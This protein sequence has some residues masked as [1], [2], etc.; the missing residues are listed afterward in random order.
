MFDHIH[1]IQQ[2][3]SCVGDKSCGVY[4][5]TAPSD[6]AGLWFGATHLQA[7]S[8]NITNRVETGKVWLNDSNSTTWMGTDEMRMIGSDQGMFT[9]GSGINAF[10]A[11][12]TN[13]DNLRGADIT[14]SSVAGSTETIFSN[15][16]TNNVRGGHAVHYKSDE[17]YYTS[18]AQATL[19]NTAGVLTS[20][21][22]NATTC[23]YD[24]YKTI[25]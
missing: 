22:C 16:P 14:A 20:G 18:S 25:G 21:G 5:N 6:Y 7:Y 9:S 11:D 3:S 23:P 2:L 24:Y 1:H 13:M 12:T 15:K 10:W 17:T 19:R 8:S 4:F